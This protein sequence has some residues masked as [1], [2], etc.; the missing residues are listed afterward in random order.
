M[1]SFSFVF[2]LAALVG[3]VSGAIADKVVREKIAGIDVIAYR[4]EIK[5]VVTFRGSLPAGD[6]FAPHENIA[7]PTLV[8]GMLDKGTTKQNKFEIAQKLENIGARISFSVG[9]VMTEFSGKCLR[10]D[11]PLVMSILA[12]ELRTPAF[13]EE[14]FAKFKKHLIGDLQR[15]L[16]STDFRAE[17]AFAA[18][19]F[20]IGHPNYEPPTKEL[21]AAVEAAKLEDLKK[22]HADY[23]G[24]A[25]AT[26]VA[27]GDID[28][29]T[30]KDEI[31][32]SFAGWSGGKARPDFEKATLPNES[33]EQTIAMADKPNVTVLIGQSSGLRYRDPDALALKIGTSA[34]G[35]GFTGRLMATVRDKEGLTYGISAG[36]SSDA[37]SDGEWRIDASF[38]PQ[39]LEK[40]VASTKREL[41]GWYAKGITAAELERVKSKTVGS[42]KVGLT[43]TDGLANALLAAVHRGFDMT[44]LDEFPKRVAALSLEEVNAAI[45]KHLRPDKMTLIKAGSVPPPVNRG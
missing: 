39:L 6:S 31:A 14:E 11:L 40:G 34:L 28:I 45:K 38:A 15:S 9:G 13:A 2:L 30:L 18:A 29:A 27:V 7:V 12:E 33:K 16:E 35:S 1:K 32:K 22:F 21:I 23:Y 4:T 43:T 24:P 44:W 3:N 8:G 5:D 37:F 25:Q 41:D 19:V 26:L 42:Y 36:S 10:K 17:Q 20:P